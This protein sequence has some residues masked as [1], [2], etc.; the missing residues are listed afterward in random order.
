MGQ[1]PTRKTATVGRRKIA[2]VGS[3]ISGLAAAY[4]LGP[5]HDVTLYEEAPTFGGH[6][7]TL[8]AGK[9]GDQP[10]DTGFIV[11]NYKTYP[12]L[13]AMFDTLKVPVI[14][15]NMSFGAT[16]NRGWLEYGL[17]NFR[18]IAAQPA[19]LVRPAYL[20]M[21]RDILRFNATALAEADC[22]DM[23]IGDLVGRM[24][25]GRWFRN[26]YLMPLCGAIWSTPPENIARFPARTLIQFFANHALLNRRN[27][28]QWWTVKGG[29]IQYVSRL[30]DHLRKHDVAL[31]PSTPVKN[32]Q[33]AATGGCLVRH[34]GGEA[35]AF[36]AVVLATHS[37]QALALIEAPSEAQRQTLSALQY[38]DNRVIL[39]ADAQ[40]MPRRRACWSS[41]IYQAD[42]DRPNPAIGVTYWMNNL[43][44]IPQ[45]DPLF[46]T[47]NPVHDIPE[48]RI[49][50][51]KI[52]RHPFFDGAAL[53]AQKKLAALQGQDN[54]WFAG[55]YTRHGF[56]EDGFASAVAIARH[57]N[58]DPNGEVL[59]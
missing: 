49:Y 30:L 46:V 29:S 53:A 6:A 25:L 33:R 56:H 58:D 47:L 38:Q 18:A 3:G 4:L 5:H 24:R 37:D 57:F 13:T 45:D 7:R 19:N 1:P 27:R 31:R 48:S 52:F 9:N 34:Q 36:D 17:S 11:F 15:S 54:I 35:E 22:D 8:I 12:H 50:D 10:V 16:I 51:E 40:Q 44:A 28:H 21:L 20:R 42:F 32:V 59:S 26:Y 55:A 2:I 39:H 23:T 43:Q 41:W 14:K